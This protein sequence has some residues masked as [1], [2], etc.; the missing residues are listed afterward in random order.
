MWS[1]QAAALHADAPPRRVLDGDNGA[2]C[3][4][5][6]ALCMDPLYWSDRSD[7]SSVGDAPWRTS[8]SSDCAAHQSGGAACAAEHGESCCL[9]SCGSCSPEEA[10]QVP[11]VLDECY[12]LPNGADYRGTVNHAVDG[13][14]CVRWDQVPGDTISIVSGPG[15]STAFTYAQLRAHSCNPR[16]GRKG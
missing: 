11:E 9:A 16:L 1:V 5:D 6:G 13:S 14:E 15:T 12:T 2:S 10:E 7:P 8:A 3:C 4:V